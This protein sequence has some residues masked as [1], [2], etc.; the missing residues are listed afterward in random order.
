[1]TSINSLSLSGLSEYIEVLP[2][3][4]NTAIPTTNNPENFIKFVLKSKFNQKPLI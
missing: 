1:M 2:V 3:K 4:I